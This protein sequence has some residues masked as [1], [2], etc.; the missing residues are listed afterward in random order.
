MNA[1]TRPAR[2]ARGGRLLWF[3]G[4]LVAVVLAGAVSALA[5]T[6]PDGLERVA[7][8][9]GFAEQAAA[10]A[11]AVADGTAGR[12]LGLLVVLA[13]ASALA[14]VLRRRHRAAPAGRR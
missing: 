4:L 1:P 9:H 5:S 3:G 12:L 10:R 11:A 6:A 7:E 14:W 2:H 13:I 8:D